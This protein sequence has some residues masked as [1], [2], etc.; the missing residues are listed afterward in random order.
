MLDP[1]EVEMMRIL[2]LLMGGLVLMLLAIPAH[3]D[4]D[5]KCEMKFNLGGWSAFYKTAKGQGTVTCDN[6]QKAE[7]TLQAKGGGLTF[8]KSEIVDGTGKFSGVR[9]IK[10]IFGTYASGGAHAGAVKSSAALGMTKGEISLSLTGTG[11]GFD[12]GVD[13]GKFII[14]RK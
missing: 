3:A 8:G 11:R 5:V 2:R 1:K 14:K 6:G 12:L 9:D 7:V 13:F 4:T 10:E